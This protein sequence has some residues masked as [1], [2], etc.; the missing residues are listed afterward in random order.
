MTKRRATPLCT[1]LKIILAN[2]IMCLKYSDAKIQ[3]VNYFYNH[4]RIFKTNMANM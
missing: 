2:L 3:A 4:K 1:V